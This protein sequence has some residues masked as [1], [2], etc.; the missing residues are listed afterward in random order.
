M[1]P[2][3][4]VNCEHGELLADDPKQPIPGLCTEQPRW[5]YVGD[6]RVHWCG[7]FSMLSQ[8]RFVVPDREEGGSDE[9]L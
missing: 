6:T 8:P 5:E 1:I 2:T 9:D 3:T 4:C 7:R